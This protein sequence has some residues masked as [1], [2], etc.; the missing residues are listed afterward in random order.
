MNLQTCSLDT[1]RMLVREWH[2]FSD[3][4]WA[5]QDLASAVRSILTPPVTQ[6]LPSGWQGGYTIDRARSWIDD[7]DKEGTTLLVVERE[8]KKPIGL[9]ILFEGSEDPL[10]PSVRIGYMLAESAW[11]Q[12]LASE[13]LEGFVDWCKKTRI[14]SIIGGVERDNMAS[15]RVLE[16]NG[17]AALSHRNKQAE[18]LYELK[19][20]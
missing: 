20:G 5:D 19:L 4:D 17:F 8:I 6:S 16:K 10:R 14:S 13:L 18:L 1:D 9:M 15:R 11:G 2:S 3:G 12:G 7:R